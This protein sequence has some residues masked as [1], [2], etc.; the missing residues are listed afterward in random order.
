MVYLAHIPGLLELAFRRESPAEQS[1]GRVKFSAG[2]VTAGDDK[3]LWI[4]DSQAQEHEQRCM[5]HCGSSA[6]TTVIVDTM[7]TTGTSMTSKNVRSEG[8]KPHGRTME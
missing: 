6:A 8:E 4:Q 2:S 1:L 7:A 5:N 3:G